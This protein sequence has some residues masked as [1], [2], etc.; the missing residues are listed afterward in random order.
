[1]FL[2]QH[3]PSPV[4]TFGY[5][6]ILSTH[7]GLQCIQMDALDRE[8]VK[9]FWLSDTLLLLLHRG[10]YFILLALARG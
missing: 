5:S 1:M 3:S 6:K 2:F 10:V 4:C 7:T 9:L 8:S